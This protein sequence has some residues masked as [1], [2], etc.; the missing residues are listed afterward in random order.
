MKLVY[1]HK[2]SILLIIF[3]LCLGMVF[4]VSRV[5]TVT[6]SDITPQDAAGAEPAQVQNIPTSDLADIPQPAIAKMVDK[7]SDNQVSFVLDNNLC[8]SECQGNLQSRHLVVDDNINKADWNNLNPSERDSALQQ[9]AGIQDTVSL[10]NPRGGRVTDGSILID[11]ADKAQVGTVTVTNGEG[12]SI[13]G[14]T[15]N[16]QNAAIVDFYGISNNVVVNFQGDRAALTYHIDQADKVQAGCFD[17]RDVDNAD[18]KINDYLEVRTVPGEEF[19]IMYGFRKEMAY[20]AGDNNVLIA[21]PAGCLQEFNLD[22]ENFKLEIPA[23]EIAEDQRKDI[24]D[25]GNISSIT[26]D[27]DLGLVCAKL[28]PTSSYSSQGKA[29]E[30]IF[31]LVVWKNPHRVCAK[32]HLDQQIELAPETTIVD[33]LSSKITMNGV[34]DY[35]RYFFNYD[36]PPVVLLSPTTISHYTPYLAFS[37]I[38][39]HDPQWK[40]ATASVQSNDAENTVTFSNFLTVKDVRQGKKRFFVFNTLIEQTADNIIQ[41]YNTVA[42]PLVFAQDEIIIQDTF[43]Q[44][45]ISVLPPGHPDIENVIKTFS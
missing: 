40:K 30:D 33:F 37:S 21:D 15:I 12:I 6:P 43:T 26:I 34:I 19:G 45:K 38:L 9:L 5:G 39:A 2:I 14:N 25:I 41:N 16:V 10:D 29:I 31:T 27:R 24:L 23:G 11:Q 32:K 28:N 1:V 4:G 17:A 44:A 13:Q 3:L 20:K 7:M 36:Q 35:R 18:I 42:H 22:G 8:N